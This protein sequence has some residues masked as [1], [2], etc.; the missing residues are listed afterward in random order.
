MSEKFRLERGMKRLADDELM[1]WKY[2]KR[3]KLANGKYR[4]WY[5]EN[6][7]TR[8]RNAN[9]YDK[10]VEEYKRS[11][12]ELDKIDRENYKT[13]KEYT[14]AYN[15][16]YKKVINASDN[17]K[18]LRNVMDDYMNNHKV[19]F[20]VDA[21]IEKIAKKTVNYL[22][23]NSKKKGENFISKLFKR[24]DKSPN[25]TVRLHSYGPKG[26]NTQYYNSKDDKWRQG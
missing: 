1:H 22:N 14:N 9:R 19:K 3:I 10:S 13:Q 2:I 12:K 25:Y 16:V 11:L 23:N 15:K 4:Y 26:S 8:R 7:N 5:D 17:E 21:L 18:H 6:S 20:V 24:K